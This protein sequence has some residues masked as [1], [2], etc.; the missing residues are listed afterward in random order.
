VQHEENT[1]GMAT[2]GITMVT[3]SNW[4]TSAAEAGVRAGR[5]CTAEQVAEKVASEAVL[6]GH[7]F[8]HV[9][10]L[11]I[12]HPSPALRAGDLLF[13]ATGN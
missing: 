2:N 6:N 5:L 13:L 7:A 1:K 11:L 8:S 9:V 3:S 12:C 4:F 10:R